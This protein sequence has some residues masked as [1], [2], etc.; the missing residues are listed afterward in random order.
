MS[1]PYIVIYA[2]FGD[3]IQLEVRDDGL[4]QVGM[5]MYIPSVAVRLTDDDVELLILAV[6]TLLAGDTDTSRRGPTDSHGT[7]LLVRTDREDE[8]HLATIGRD[9]ITTKYEVFMSR[10]QA[11]DLV[12]GL[13]ITRRAARDRTRSVV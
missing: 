12:V 4:L 8:V 1:T 6:L 2:L 5:G 10:D 11:I 13:A 9:G 7:T 3:I